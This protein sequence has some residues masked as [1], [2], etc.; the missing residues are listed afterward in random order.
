VTIRGSL[1]AR[2]TRRLRAQLADR[3][4]PGH[5]AIVMDGNRRWA[6]QMAFGNVSLGHRYGAEHPLAL[7][8]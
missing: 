8:S 1:Y 4:L 7:L 5:V 3:P 6:R 2:Y